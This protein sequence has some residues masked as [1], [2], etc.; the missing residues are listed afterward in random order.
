MASSM[1][2]ENNLP[3]YFRV[4]AVNATCYVMSRVLRPFIRKTLYEILFG[5][6]SLNIIF[7][8]IWL[9]KFYM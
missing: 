5:R 7:Q 3:K 9:E 4:E 6:N 2:C 8:N 1:L